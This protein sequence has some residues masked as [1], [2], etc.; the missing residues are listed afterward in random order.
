MMKPR[1]VLLFVLLAATGC[2]SDSAVP[3]T[4]PSPPGAEACPDIW[5]HCVEL[6]HPRGVQDF[7]CWSERP[8]VDFNCECLDGMTPLEE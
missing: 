2:S 5:N 1:V 7:G 6:C 8:G 4:V 3:T